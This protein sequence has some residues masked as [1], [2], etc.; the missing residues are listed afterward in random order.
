MSE[1]ERGFRAGLER[2]AKH[3]EYIADELGEDNA[4]G[5]MNERIREDLEC[6]RAIR[7]LIPPAGSATPGYDFPAGAAPVP[8]FR[9]LTAEE[10]A[11]YEAVD[12][13]PAV[14]ASEGSVV[15]TLDIDCPHCGTPKGRACGAGGMVC[16][17]RVRQAQNLSVRQPRRPTD[18]EMYDALGAE[19]ERHP[20]GPGPRRRA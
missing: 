16:M 12:T 15:T 5:C 13:A 19:I 18:D 9:A 6:A 11:T 3:C 4:A 8:S 7:A 20:L 2:A 17:K 14:Q 1:Y 10:A